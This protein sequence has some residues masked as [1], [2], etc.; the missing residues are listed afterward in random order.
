MT[1]IHGQWRIVRGAK[2]DAARMSSREQRTSAAELCP[3]GRPRGHGGI[4]IRDR[5]SRKLLEVPNVSRVSR[6]K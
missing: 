3:L 1:A 4:F 5:K 6:R 2:A